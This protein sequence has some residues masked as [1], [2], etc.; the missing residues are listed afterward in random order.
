MHETAEEIKEFKKMV[1]I[2]ARTAS[3]QMKEELGLP[4]KKL[5]GEQVLRYLQGLHKFTFAVTTSS[6]S[7]QIALAKALVYRGKFYIPST[8]TAL[9][10]RYLQHESRVSLAKHKDDDIT[11]IVNGRASILPPNSE[12]EAER[13]EFRIVEEIHRMYSNEVPS[14]MKNG[15]FIRVTPFTICGAASDPASYPT[16]AE[17]RQKETAT[18]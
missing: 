2:S 8:T 13:E 17:R 5:N 18:A 7:P 16:F 3:P 6:G 14:E 1:G 10:T 4:D 9:R 12:D 11:L 15:C